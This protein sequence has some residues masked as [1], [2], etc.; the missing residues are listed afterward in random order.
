MIPADRIIFGRDAWLVVPDADLDAE[1]DAARCRA[2]DRPCDAMCNGDWKCSRCIDG[3]HT[4]DI[5]VACP[6]PDC[7]HCTAGGP[8]YR[9]RVSVVPGMVLPIADGDLS[10]LLEQGPCIGFDDYGVPHLFV[11]NEPPAPITLPPAAAP[12][13]YA[14][15]LKVAS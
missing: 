15:K 14:V 4:S 8:M 2:L 9:Y 7:P 13:M 12:G 11:P 10:A 6:D 1:W 5:S 3:R